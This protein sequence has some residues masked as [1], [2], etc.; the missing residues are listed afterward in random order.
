[1]FAR[2]VRM[3]LKPNSTGEFTRVLESDITP[4]LRKQRGFRDEIAFLAQGGKEAVAISFWDEK[5]QAEA[6][7][8]SAYP[9]VLKALGRVVDGTPQVQ[10]YDVCHSTVR[11]IAA[12]MAA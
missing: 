7:S 1:M 5:E 8:R 11:D 6:Y 4:Q 3:N 12:R 2:I 10:T 9:E